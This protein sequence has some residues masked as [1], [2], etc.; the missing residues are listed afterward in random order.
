[1]LLLLKIV[2][3]ILLGIEFIKFSLW[4]SNIVDLFLGDD[5]WGDFR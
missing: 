3:G 1:M 5:T 4:L 2:V